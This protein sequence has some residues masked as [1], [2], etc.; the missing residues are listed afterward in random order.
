MEREITNMDKTYKQKWD[1]QHRHPKCQKHH[2]KIDNRVLLKKRKENKLSPV[3]GKEN[4]E[5]L[6]TSGSTVKAR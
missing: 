2:F 1:Y 6:E 5:I 3:H 4:D